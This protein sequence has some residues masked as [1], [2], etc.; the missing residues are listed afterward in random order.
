MKD[1]AVFG[2]ICYAKRPEKPECMENSYVVC[3]DGKCAGV[4]DVL[5]EK[6]RGIEVIDLTDM[7]ITPGFV[8]LHVHAPQYAYRGL[9]MDL[10]LLD[11]LD[12]ITFPQEARY[13]DTE[14]A[15]QAY[16]VFVG[17]LKKS[18]TTR[19]CIFATIHKDAT[20]ELMR[21]LENAGLAGFVGKVNMD[22]N[23]PDI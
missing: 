5:P 14:Y 6:Y 19:S 9:G 17:D 4:F 12:T 7:I 18:A 10:E 20:V 21:Q 22:R 11:W 1:F 13:A 3:V 8:D 2:D 15:A 16:E 23:S